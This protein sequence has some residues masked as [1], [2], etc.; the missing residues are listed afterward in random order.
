MRGIHLTADLYGCDHEHDLLICA[1][2]LAALSR[3]AV[4]ASGL[5]A[6]G[7]HWHSFP[8]VLGRR[9]GVTGMVL[10]AESHLAVHTWPERDAVTLDVFVCNLRRD[11]TD[12]AERLMACLI[13]AF[14]PRKRCENRLIR[15][16]LSAEDPTPGPT[17]LR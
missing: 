6:V 17:D 1:D 3:R 9:G 11:N 4:D 16:D 10:L 2:A 15:G 8:A 13:D 14:R 7:E 5:E 12:R